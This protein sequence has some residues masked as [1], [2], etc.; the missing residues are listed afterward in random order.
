MKIKIT[1]I[2]I[3]LLIL[4]SSCIKNNVITPIDNNPIQKL[5]VAEKNLLY[6][7]NDF[8]KEKNLDTLIWNEYLATLAR[9]HSKD[10][11][12]GKFELGYDE[13]NIRK[14]SIAK[15]LPYTSYMELVSSTKGN[16]TD[17]AQEAYSMFHSFSE[18][19]LIGNYKTAGVGVETS[20][21]GRYYFTI[22]F[23]LPK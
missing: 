18:N 14:D 10:M 15:H 21:D 2:Q 8:R 9:V 3:I 16:S 12:V 19:I 22:I 6:L 23:V 7:I 1:I 20:S 13:Q 4:L 17:K 11:A 5:D